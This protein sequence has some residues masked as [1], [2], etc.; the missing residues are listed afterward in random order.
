MTTEILELSRKCKR[1]NCRVELE[2]NEE[3]EENEASEEDVKEEAASSSLQPSQRAQRLAKIQE[4]AEERYESLQEK[5][6]EALKKSMPNL[7]NNEQAEK[8][9]LER[10][11]CE[12]GDRNFC[13]PNKRM[14]S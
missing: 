10:F 13:E 5:L 4:I 1:K 2:E 6:P 8:N 9:L 14:G 12:E 7:R 11:L 3:R